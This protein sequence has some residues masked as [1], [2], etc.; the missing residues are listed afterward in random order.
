[1]GQLMLDVLSKVGSQVVSF[2]WAI[3]IASPIV[4]HFLKKGGQ[5]TK[6]TGN[7]KS[8]QSYSFPLHSGPIPCLFLSASQHHR[9]IEALYAS[10]VATR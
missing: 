1:M 3:P 7:P 8:R 4:S 10:A 6:K 2:R 9:I 5:C